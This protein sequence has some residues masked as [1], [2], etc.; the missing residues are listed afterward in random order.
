MERDQ[1]GAGG[2]VSDTVLLYLSY[3]LTFTPTWR[4]SVNVFITYVEK[5]RLRLS[6]LTS[7]RSHSQWLN[8]GLSSFKDCALLP[9][10]YCL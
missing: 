4:R 3:H 9:P 5:L 8:S 6:K 7:Y 2:D 10:L 1:S